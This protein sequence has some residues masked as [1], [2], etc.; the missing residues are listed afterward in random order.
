[1]RVHL[2]LDDPQLVVLAGIA[3]RG[4]QEEAVELRLGSGNVPSCSI[5]FSVASTRNG[6][7]AAA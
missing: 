4:L 5:G 3:E 7:G 6:S 1:V 2:L